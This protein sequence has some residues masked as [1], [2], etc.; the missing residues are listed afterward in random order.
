MGESLPKV[1]FQLP[2]LFFKGDI[3]MRKGVDA[4]QILAIVLA[5]PKEH[6]KRNSLINL[7]NTALVRSGSLPADKEDKFMAII[8]DLQ[9]EGAL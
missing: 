8:K 1:F 7:M 5:L 2:H 6:P 4:A 3:K 9:K